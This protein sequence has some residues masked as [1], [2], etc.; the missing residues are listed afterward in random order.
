MEKLRE[1]KNLGIPVTILVVFAYLIGYFL[2]KNMSGTLIIALIF[3]AAVFTLNFDDKVKNA[4]KHS[5]VFAILFQLIYFVI[6]LITS[7]ASLFNGGLDNI[8]IENFFY[9]FNYFRSA[10]VFFPIFIILLLSFL[11]DA[12]VTAVYVICIIM[13]LIGKD[14]KIG[15]ISNILGESQSK[16]TYSRPPF[17]RQ[18]N[19]STTHMQSQTSQPYEQAPS[20]QI[21]AQSIQAPESMEDLK[22]NDKVHM[23]NTENQGTVCTRCG[24]V[25]ENDA[26]YCGSC[27]TKLK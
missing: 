26:I 16:N 15:I 4:V 18:N 23:T 10:P 7:F 20:D 13:T 11:V 5:Y 21:S 2:S 27:G 22:E 17:G 24:R 19:G 12:A 9:S 3:A 8:K 14:V 25:N 6:N 1:K